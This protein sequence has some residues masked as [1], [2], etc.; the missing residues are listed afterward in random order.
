QDFVFTL[1]ESRDA[2]WPWKASSNDPSVNVELTHENDDGV[3]KARVNVKP[4][5]PGTVL[6][7]LTCGP[8]TVA[9]HL[10]VK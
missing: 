2:S 1:E 9:V 5:R 8:K 3:P 4:R 7:A 10:T 6:L